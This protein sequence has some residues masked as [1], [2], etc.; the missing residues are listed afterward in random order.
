MGSS[1]GIVRRQADMQRAIRAAADLSHEVQVQS[2]PAGWP[3]LWP[4]C[5]LQTPGAVCCICASRD[6]CQVGKLTLPWQHVRAELDVQMVMMPCQVLL[7]GIG[8]NACHLLFQLCACTAC[9]PPLLALHD[10]ASMMQPFDL[11][12][13]PC[14][15]AI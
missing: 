10:A 12:L 6:Q 9:I 14:A 2:P 5:H 11:L 8:A 13:K 3:V 15:S 4:R 1:A 7:C